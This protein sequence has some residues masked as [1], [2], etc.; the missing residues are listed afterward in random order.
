[1]RPGI[2]RIRR[3]LRHGSRWSVALTSGARGESTIVGWGDDLSEAIA[4]FRAVAHLHV[5][6]VSSRPL[7]Q[8]EA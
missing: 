3:P 1:M 4:R 7:P 5:V 2:V 8:G 6:F